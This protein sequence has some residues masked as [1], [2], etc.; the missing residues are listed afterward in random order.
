MNL[1]TLQLSHEEAEQAGSPIPDDYPVGSLRDNP[2]GVEEG[3]EIQIILDDLNDGEGTPLAST[4][5]LINLDLLTIIDSPTRTPAG[6]SD[7]C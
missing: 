3:E 5:N 6:P 2:E 4:L 7:P 1:N